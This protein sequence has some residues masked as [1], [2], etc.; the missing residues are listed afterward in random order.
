MFDGFLADVGAFLSYFLAGGVA[1]VVY[2]YVYTLVTPHN[3]VELIKDQ[4]QAAALAFAG[5]LIGF[6]LPITA[7]IESAIDLVDFGLWAVVAIVVQI[8]AFFV[9]KLFFPRIS[10]RIEAGEVPAG[11][12]LAGASIAAG[13]LNAAC[14]S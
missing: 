8:A 4:N 5:S 7:L 3:E 13:M 14:L 10:E 2:M 1:T 12:W 6:V 11:T 9:V